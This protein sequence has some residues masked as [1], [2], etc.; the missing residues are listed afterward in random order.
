MA[1]LSEYEQKRQET[2]AKNKALLRGLALDASEAGLG[3]GRR[4]KAAP[5]KKAS[6]GRAEQKKVKVEVQAPTR[7][8]SRL[9]GIVADSEQAKRKADEEQEVVREQE[10]VKRQRITEDLN[11]SDITVAGHWDAAGNFLNG[12][13]PAKPNERTFTEQHVKDTS[14]KELKALRERMSGLELWDAFEPNKTK[15]TPERIYSLGFHPTED[16]PLVFAGDK[17]GNL[18]LCDCSQSAPEVKQ[19]RGED[20]EDDETDR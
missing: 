15:I 10:R 8:S 13:G 3:P 9:K 2:I 5:Q 11:L 6:K 18:G 12:I 19:E 7:T 17:L 14:D 1:V 16:K 20:E 4:A